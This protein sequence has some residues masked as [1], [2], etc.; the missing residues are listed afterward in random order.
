MAKVVGAVKREALA[1]GKAGIV[2]GL[3]TGLGARFA[4]SIGT[5]IG[6]IVAGAMLGGSDGRIV[7]INGIM[8]ATA[9]AISG[10]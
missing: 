2:G 10:Y 7:T 8:D 5:A 6:A 4:G 1:G 9:L 3:A